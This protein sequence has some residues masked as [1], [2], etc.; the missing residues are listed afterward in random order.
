M[1]VKTDVKTDGSFTAL[2]QTA[3]NTA[4]LNKYNFIHN[5][6]PFAQL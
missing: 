2:K 1:I 6:T 4:L 3:D 5:P